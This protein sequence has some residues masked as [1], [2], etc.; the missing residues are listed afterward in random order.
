MPSSSCNE[1]NSFTWLVESNRIQKTN[2]SENPLCSL[3]LSVPSPRLPPFFAGNVS[4]GLPW[5]GGHC[6]SAP[7]LAPA[8]L[9]QPETNLSAMFDTTRLVTDR[10][11]GCSDKSSKRL[12]ALASH[13]QRCT[14]VQLNSSRP[15]GVFTVTFR[16][17]AKYKLGGVP[18]QAH[19]L[20]SQADLFGRR[21]A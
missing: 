15:P 12:T 4:Q 7:A 3:P 21:G 5:L 19:G 18:H 10:L 16:I 1:A 13:S 2:D 6:V 11:P 14:H 9:S 8:S 20:A 17:L